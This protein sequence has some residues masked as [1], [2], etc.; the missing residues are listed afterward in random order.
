ME[1]TLMRLLRKEQMDNKK[2]V[3]ASNLKSIVKA[4]KIHQKEKKKM[5]SGQIHVYMNQLMKQSLR[6]M[7]AR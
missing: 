2:I 1:I 6:S 4:I 5:D 3:Q 7:K